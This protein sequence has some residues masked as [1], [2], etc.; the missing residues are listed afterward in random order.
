MG[1]QI[2][3]FWEEPSY[4][5]MLIRLASF[6]RVIIFK[7]RGTG[8]SDQVTDMPSLE[9]RMDDVRAVMDTAKVEKAA[10]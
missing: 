7:K 9:V 6:A 3:L 2:D 8:L 10:L 5:R 4:A 1:L